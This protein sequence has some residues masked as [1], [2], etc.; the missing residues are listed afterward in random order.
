M[1]E[2]EA[3]TAVRNH[4]KGIMKNPKLEFASNSEANHQ[5][6][7]IDEILKYFPDHR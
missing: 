1:K 4:S 7:M 3:D 5:N 2:G 6:A